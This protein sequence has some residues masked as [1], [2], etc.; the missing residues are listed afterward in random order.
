MQD[1]SGFFAL[2]NRVAAL[3]KWREECVMREKSIAIVDTVPPQDF[4]CTKCRTSDFDVI[5]TES[6][7]DL[8]IWVGDTYHE[9]CIPPGVK[10][11]RVSAKPSTHSAE[12]SP[13][14]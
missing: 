1:Y 11:Q 3:E 13:S 9:T 12:S 2:A 14:P 7:P 5:V 8:N 6:R 4:H 10:Y